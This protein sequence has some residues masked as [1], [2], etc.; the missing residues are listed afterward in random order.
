MNLFVDSD[1]GIKL[2]GNDAKCAKG[3]VGRRE[4]TFIDHLLYARLYAGGFTLVISSK[5]HINSCE[6]DV[7]TPREVK[8]LEVE[9]R[10]EPWTV[11]L[12]KILSGLPINMYNLP[13]SDPK[14]ANIRAGRR[15][16]V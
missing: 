4:Q 3:K 2:Y 7:V 10:I 14:Q 15:A 11:R 12:K 1:W 13:H 5:A 8:Q 6:A 9:P 16:S